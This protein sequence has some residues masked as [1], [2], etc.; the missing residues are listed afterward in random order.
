MKY[1]IKRMRTEIENQTIKRIII[2]LS[3]H[4]RKKDKKKKTKDHNTSTCTTPW[5]KNDSMSNKTTNNQ[6]L[7]AGDVTCAS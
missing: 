7:S 1:E 5:G 3:C 4:E 6:I 2:Y